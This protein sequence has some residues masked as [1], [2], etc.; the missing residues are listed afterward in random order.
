MPDPTLAQIALAELT[1][2]REQALAALRARQRSEAQVQALLRPWAAIAAWCGADVRALLH[3]A[4][5]VPASE[6]PSWIDF[7]PPRTRADDALRALAH[8]CRRAYAVALTKPDTERA[9]N[10]ARL[11]M[12]LSIAAGLPA[13][14]P[15]PKAAEQV[16]A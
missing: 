3:P 6:V 8:E 2:R 13:W 1:R 9:A 12:R 16:A 15:E 11:D 7:C 14:Q 4:P 10:L 5:G